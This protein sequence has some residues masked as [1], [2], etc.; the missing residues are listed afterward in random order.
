[1][2]G[3]EGLVVGVSWWAMLHSDL[4]AAV[5]NSA[6]RW[7]FGFPPLELALL[8]GGWSVSDVGFIWF[9]MFVLL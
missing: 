8:A 1:M 5:L 6:Q 9:G 7:M 2:L 4:P 3:V